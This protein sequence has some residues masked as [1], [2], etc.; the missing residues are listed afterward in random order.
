VELE[1][2]GRA[3]VAL[4]AGLVVACGSTHPIETGTPV[5]SSS[6]DRGPRERSAVAIAPFTICEGPS[7][8]ES[9]GYL[10]P[11]WE[12]TCAGCHGT[13][14]EGISALGAP[15]LPTPGG[16][17]ESFR[18]V[19]RAGRKKMPAFDREHV[20]DAELDADFA[21]LS[22]RP[23]EARRA[24][25]TM[26][27]GADL[28]ARI[29]ARPVDQALA[30]GLVAWRT[31]GERG[32][33]ASCHGPEGI[34]LARIGFTDADLLRRA[35]GQGLSSD[36]AQKI[37]RMI[38]ALRE[39]YEIDAFCDPRAPFLQPGHGV[40]PGATKAE[41]DLALVDELSRH[42]IHLGD[43]VPI[44]TVAEANQTI[45][46]LLSTWMIGLRV[47][48]AMNR[49]TEDGTLGDEHL[50]SAEWIPEY[51]SHP[52]PEHEAEWYAL[53]D[54]Y[55]AEPT[56][57]NLWAISDAVP[58]LT[59]PAPAWT[60]PPGRFTRWNQR[61]YQAV[62]LGQHLLRTNRAERPPTMSDEELEFY[63]SGEKGDRRE[64][65]AS[66]GPD[67]IWG[68]GST[69]TSSG[70]ISIGELR[71]DMA[72][73]T[74]DTTRLGR[75]EKE[76]YDDTRRA[77]IPWMWLAHALDP[78]RQFIE[79]GNSSVEY[80]VTKFPG[81]EG[82]DLP[83]HQLMQNVFIS[84]GEVEGN[85]TRVSVGGRLAGTRRA[86]NGLWTQHKVWRPVLDVPT[87]G[88]HGKPVDPAE[89]RPAFV[90]APV[91]PSP[92]DASA[93]ARA[94]ITASL[95][96]VILLLTTEQIEFSNRCEGRRTKGPDLGPTPEQLDHVRAFLEAVEPHER[97]WIATTIDH[98][99]TLLRR[100]DRGGGMDLA[101]FRAA[102][103]VRP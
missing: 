96:H 82:R 94:K 60:G 33:C 1:T 89:L 49:W 25:A 28:R 79:H 80:Y 42:E 22:A 70:G 13:F 99:S 100:C 9:R 10:S 53:H 50:S 7:R 95:W 58:K 41:R 73:F 24:A 32:A 43:G 62:L 17:L 64:A 57:A 68:V 29:S 38:H 15:A 34:D 56:Y 85:D 4:G 59:G 71:P 20:A 61:K 65:I 91:V 35:M 55:L 76:L 44:H 69:M 6:G 30:E 8:R 78:S 14:G 63:H 97:A 37:V 54:R 51:P 40:L 77:G 3:F 21:K 46:N 16:D 27:P 101:T 5:S 18:A 67:A 47:G 12:A 87:S 81:R 48:F 19:V 23:V 11:T 90:G 93:V 72:P 36:D 2:I 45:A 102:G 103:G 84:I 98:L 31:V 88:P 75:S 66:R 39:R 83:I 52:L 26:R 92:D 86:T 74:T